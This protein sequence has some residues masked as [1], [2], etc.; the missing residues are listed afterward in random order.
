MH[1]NEL[2]R[3]S[4]TLVP[5][6]QKNIATT[7][8]RLDQTQT[9]VL[10]IVT[11]KRLLSWPPGTGRR[12]HDHPQNKHMASTRKCMSRTGVQGPGPRPIDICAGNASKSTS[13]P[14]QATLPAYSGPKNN[15]V[16]L[17]QLGARIANKGSAA[18]QRDLP[19]VC[20]LSSLDQVAC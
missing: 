20:K 12:N 4:S 3:C 11:C 2:R 10:G 7:L 1:R 8:L 16:R 5:S 13:Q 18:T 6:S 9:Q 15:G 14:Q 19:G 17:C